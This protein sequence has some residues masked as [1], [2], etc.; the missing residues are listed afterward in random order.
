MNYLL[1]LRKM[2]N[3]YFR[4]VV[5][6]DNM[7]AHAPFIKRLEKKF[8]NA[9]VELF[10]TVEKGTDDIL[11]NINSKTVVFMDCKFDLG[12]QGFDGLKK[13]RDATSLIGIV[14]MSANS[15]DHFENP[16]IQLMIN[17]KDIYFIR[18]NDLIEAEEK[19]KNIIQEWNTRIDC[20]LEQWV[21]NRKATNMDEPYIKTEEGIKSLSEILSEIRKRTAIGLR[22]ERNI[23]MLAIDLL[24]KDNV[25][26]RI[27]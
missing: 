2:N 21:L 22:L 4:I 13:I 8:P 27:V 9:S 19:V 18:N 7:R 11:S 10:D 20:V 15:I 17:S 25:K 12:L 5:V 16:D 3:L 1:N 26:S 23:L 24:T 6:D 14:M